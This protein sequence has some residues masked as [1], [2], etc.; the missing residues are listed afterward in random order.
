V[1]SR[2]LHPDE[3]DGEKILLDLVEQ[4]LYFAMDQGLPGREVGVFLSFYISALDLITRE[5][6]R[7]KSLE[8]IQ[9]NGEK[10]SALVAAA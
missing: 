7:S 6:G 8:N 5:A 2:R 4:A 1:W 9:S 10:C 3:Y